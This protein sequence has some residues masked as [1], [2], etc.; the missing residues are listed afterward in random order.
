MRALYPID[1]LDKNKA[2]G[3]YHEEFIA[4]REAGY[5]CSLFDFDALAFGEFKPYPKF[6]EGDRI[7]YRG[8]MMNAERYQTFTEKVA[9]SGGVPITSLATY[10]RCHY[11]PKWYSLCAEFTAE[12]RFFE[13]NETLEDAIRE[14]GWT[15][16]FVKDFVKSNT[17]DRGSIARSPA[18]VC[19]IVEQLSAYRGEVEGGVAVR[20][21]EEY[22]PQTECRYFVVHKRPYSFDGIVPDIVQS[23]A[24]R[25]ESPFYSVD[26]AQRTDGALR[27]I[28]LGD[29]QVSDKKM[30]PLPSFLEVMTKASAITGR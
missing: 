30:W 2:D 24:A 19:E 18:E 22:I 16:Y 14:L 9:A 20:R 7:L 15:S 29:G 10:L 3:P 28:E 21:V 8:W 1:P 6:E 23:I 4:A 12:T 26:V 11:L 17:G 25:I 5:A 13:A 27:L